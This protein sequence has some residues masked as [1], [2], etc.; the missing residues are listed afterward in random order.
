MLLVEPVTR[1]V[2]FCNLSVITPDC[3]QAKLDLQVQKRRD[4][5]VFDRE[6]MPMALT[7]KGRATRSR[8]IEGASSLL[9]DDGSAELTLDSVMHRTAT[10][11]SQL[12]HYFPGGKEE[13]LL[14]VA[15]HEA[16]RVLADQEPHLSSLDSRESWSAWQTALISRYRAQGA[17][18]PLSALMAQVGTV[19]GAAEVSSVLLAQWQ[20]RLRRGVVVMQERGE[21][22]LDMN[23]DRIAA[24]L[25]A[26][27]QGG[28]AVLRATGSTQ[29][30][31]AGIEV[32]LGQVMN[33][34][35]SGRRTGRRASGAPPG[36]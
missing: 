28:V 34:K 4:R 25:I 21:A 27:I 14:A 2:L 35:P 10:S 16:D 33:E 26:A 15:Q 1:A 22:R 11:K 9:R 19:P 8:I 6:E 32:L 3:K 12:F 13:L 20:E 7:A 30:L 18:C 23:P 36:T 29:H 24:A 17:N 5:M 31:E